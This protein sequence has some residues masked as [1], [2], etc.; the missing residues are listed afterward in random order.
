MDGVGVMLKVV[1][2]KQVGKIK[3]I[4]HTDQG[5]IG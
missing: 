1:I 2:A 5:V 4:A 3:K